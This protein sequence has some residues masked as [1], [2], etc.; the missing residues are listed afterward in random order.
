ME[1][2]KLTL[3]RF[4]PISV[5]THSSMKPWHTLGL[6]AVGLF[7]ISSEPKAYAQ[8]STEIA[9][10]K[11]S[12]KVFSAQ[13]AS[14]SQ[15]TPIQLTNTQTGLPVK[16]I[17]DWPNLPGKFILNI[18][19]SKRNPTGEDNQ[20][21]ILSKSTLFLE[22]LGWETDAVITYPEGETGMRIEADLRDENQNLVLESTYPLPVISK[23]LRILKLTP[24][25]P[26]GHSNFVIP[27]FT[28]VETIAG[29]IT[30]PAKSYLAAGSTLHVQLLENALAGGLSMEMAAQETRP[31]ILTDGK[32]QFSMRRGLW[33]RPDEP[34]LAFKAWITDPRGRK[35][36]VMR[37][38]VSY[39]GP[40]VNYHLSLDGLRQGTDTKRGRDPNLVAFTQTLVQGEAEFDP[41]NGIP[42][43]ARLNI[44]LKQDR[45]DF[46]Q[47]PILT[48]QT[49]IIPS[50]TTRI[51]F[52]LVAASIYFDPYVPAP[53]LSVSLTDKTGHIYYDSGEV[54]ARESQNL[55]RLFPR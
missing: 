51:P 35:S 45:G 2:R 37:K 27:D 44:K 49:L 54:R 17:Y 18:T 3:P 40:E 12:T 22:D 9:T 16:V 47:N 39:N 32:I 36:F 8:Y 7:F 46:N 41:V 42:E 11:P 10:P 30:L 23:E 48:E 50:N 14:N 55:V 15:Q 5:A 1:A 21:I 53:I 38:P 20:D 13:A 31:A 25:S 33:D 19:L 52:S 26:I 29:K 4:R 24:P 43:Q 34:D 6:L 28:G